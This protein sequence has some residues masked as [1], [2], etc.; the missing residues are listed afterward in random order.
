MS[1]LWR[2]WRSRPKTSWARSILKRKNPFRDLTWPLF[3]VKPSIDE[4]GWWCRKVGGAGQGTAGKEVSFVT[5]KRPP[6][7][8]T[9]S[10]WRTQWNTCQPTMK[11]LDLLKGGWAG[12]KLWSLQVNVLAARALWMIVSSKLRIEVTGSPCEGPGPPQACAASRSG[13]IRTGITKCSC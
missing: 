6:P 11:L 7:T 3:Y 13:S 8:W 4:L 1:S 12:W 2:R 9:L 10:P 5:L